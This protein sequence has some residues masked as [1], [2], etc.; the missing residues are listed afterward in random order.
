MCS[1]KSD[2][3]ACLSETFIFQRAVNNALCVF[4]EGY[5]DRQY[6]ADIGHP[7]VL[8]NHHQDGRHDHH[9]EEDGR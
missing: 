1:R 3:M 4:S 5:G 6:D 7:L 9:N 2:N 8:E